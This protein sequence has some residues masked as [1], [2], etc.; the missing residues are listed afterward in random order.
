LSTATYHD[1]LHNTE[2]SL[3]Q[4]CIDHFITKSLKTTNQLFCILNCPSVVC[5]GG[6]ALW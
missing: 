2:E 1:K 4:G 3:A 6:A 5:M